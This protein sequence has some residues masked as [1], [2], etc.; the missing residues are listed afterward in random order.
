MKNLANITAIILY[1][2]SNDSITKQ[3]IPENEQ[4]YALI[5]IAWFMATGNQQQINQLLNDNNQQKTYDDLHEYFIEMKN[6]N[7]ANDESNEMMYDVCQLSLE[8]ITLMLLLEPKYSNF[9]SKSICLRRFFIDLLL[10]QPIETI[11]IT[12]AEQFS[13]II[14]INLSI[15][16]SSS[17][18]INIG[19]FI[20]ELIFNYLQTYLLE[21]Y[22]TS[23]QFFQFCCQ[24][25]E[26]IFDSIQQQQQPQQSLLILINKFIEYEYNLLSCPKVSF[27]LFL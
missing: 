13:F 19:S 7:N 10:I 25:L 26:I 17:S 8:T 6:S 12:M 16:S 23:R 5:R 15:N 4:I 1:K 3:F 22:Q 9:L 24:L 14:L 11:R 18:S 20:L 27:F 2:E 21:F